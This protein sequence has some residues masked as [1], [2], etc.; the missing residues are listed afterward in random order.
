MFKGKINRVM[1][2]GSIKKGENYPFDIK[3]YLGP[4]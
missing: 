2:N 1:N 3:F 4:D